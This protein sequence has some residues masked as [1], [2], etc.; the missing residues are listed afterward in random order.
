MNASPELWEDLPIQDV[1]PHKGMMSLLTRIIAY[2]ED[3]IS[4]VAEIHPDNPFLVDEKGVPV[5]IGFEY[6]AQTMAAFA[7]LASLRDNVPLKLGVLVGC[8]RA[9]CARPYFVVGQK[10]RISAKL[11]WE[12]DGMGN[13]SA[14]I[15]DDATNEELMSGR[16]NVYQPDDPFEY[17][18]LSGAV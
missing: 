14:Q 4:T 1:I 6:M 7:G 9:V 11:D 18:N 15:F 16:V 5:C 2:T 10:L 8:R 3:S 17:F 13:F 12:S